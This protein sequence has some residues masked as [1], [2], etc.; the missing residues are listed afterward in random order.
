MD[1][2]KLSRSERQQIVEILERRS[3]ELTMFYHEYRSSP[4]SI[5]SVELSLEREMERL[6]LL[7]LKVRPEEIEE[8]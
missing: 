8:D 3:N 2:L 4:N 7:A 1:I 6:D 5:G